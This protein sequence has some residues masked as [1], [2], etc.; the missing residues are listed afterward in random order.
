MDGL[1]YQI[2]LAYGET[3]LSNESWFVIGITEVL[4]YVKRVFKIKIRSKRV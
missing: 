4:G 2:R 3:C 1:W